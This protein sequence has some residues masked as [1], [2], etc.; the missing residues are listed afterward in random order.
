[1]SLT[2]YRRFSSADGEEERQSHLKDLLH[3]VRSHHFNEN[4][5]TKRLKELHLQHKF[6]R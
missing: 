2:A 6:C 3:S 5:D 1:M 4:F